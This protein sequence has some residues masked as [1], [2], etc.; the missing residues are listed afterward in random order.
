MAFIDSTEQQIPSST[1]NR[2]RK[3]FVC[4]YQSALGQTIYSQRR[5][6]IEPLM[7]HI[8]SVFRTDPLPA[9]GYHAI[10]TTILLSVLLYQLI[11]YYNCKTKKINPKSIKYMLGTI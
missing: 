5:I 8:K 4:F 9:R 1:D 11:I 10:S 2:R 6:S 7:E 3:A